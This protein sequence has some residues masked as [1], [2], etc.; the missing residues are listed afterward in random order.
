MMLLSDIPIRDPFIL[1]ENGIYYLY[2]TRG[3]TCW[4][5]ADGFDV[6]TSRDLNHWD[7][8]KVCFQRPDD[9]WA[10][11][12]FW[13]PEVHRWQGAYYLFATF[14]GCGCRGTA[15]LRS[16]RPEGPFLPHSDGPVTPQNWECLDGTLYVNRNSEPYLVFC[17][18]W[19]QTVDGEIHAMALQPD[20]KA[21]A[22]EPFLLFRASEAPWSVPI[23][24]GT[25]TG[26]VTDGPFLWRTEK[27]ALLCLWSGF[28]ESGYTQGLALS[29]SGEI[30][31]PYRQLP[32]LYTADGGHGMLF[33]AFDGQVYLLLHSPNQSPLERSKLVPWRP[34]VE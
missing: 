33:H 3:K 23:S 26:Q 14:Q 16:D 17:H 19:L 20:L 31:G 15:I 1:A 29:E 27:G 12:C 7:G 30:N 2:G 4:G 28:S 24:S 34:P 6:Y 9:F 8:P 25:H 18:E 5:A 10:D 13:A 32:P 11:R 22:G 21:P